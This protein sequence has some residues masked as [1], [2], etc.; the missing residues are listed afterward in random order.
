MCKIK[1]ILRRKDFPASD[2]N[3]VVDGNLLCV[4]VML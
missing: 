2:A 3:H 1:K 4:V